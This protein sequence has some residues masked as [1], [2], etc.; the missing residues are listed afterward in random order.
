MVTCFP[1][2]ETDKG[3]TFRKVSD[4]FSNIQIILSKVGIIYNNHFF[5]MERHLIY[6]KSSIF[7]MSL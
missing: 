3:E 4:R 6:G 7:A 2:G 5:L 1:C